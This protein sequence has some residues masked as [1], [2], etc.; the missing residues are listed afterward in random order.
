M[1]DTKRGES[2]NNDIM[3]KLNKI[4]EVEPLKDEI[5]AL[6]DSNLNDT[7]SLKEVKKQIKDREEADK[8]ILRLPKSIGVKLRKEAEAEGVSLNQFILMT[9][10][11][12]LGHSG[13]R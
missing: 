9:T 1:I 8:F 11:F 6:A 5:E 3:K 12:Y 13:N 2:M 4:V 10:A 7:V